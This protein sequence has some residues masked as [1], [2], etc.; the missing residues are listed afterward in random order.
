MLH[1]CSKSQFKLMLL[2]LC[3]IQTSFGQAPKYLP[4]PFLRIFP[5]L[6]DFLKEAMI[7]RERKKNRLIFC[8]IFLPEYTGEKKKTTK[9]MVV[10]ASKVVDTILHNEYSSMQFLQKHLLYQPDKLLLQYL[11]SK[12][13][14]HLLERSLN[15]N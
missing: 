12:G 1:L 4:L 15:W 14:V 3:P 13:T 2:F 6:E 10:T 8:I 5:H 7:G 11:Q 9:K